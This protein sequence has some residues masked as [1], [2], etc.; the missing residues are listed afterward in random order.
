[1]TRILSC[2]QLIGLKADIMGGI[3]VHSQKEA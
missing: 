2:S 3:I 1:V